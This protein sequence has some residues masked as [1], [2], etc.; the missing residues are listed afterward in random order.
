VSYRLALTDN[1]EWIGRLEG[2][3]DHLSDPLL[4]AAMPLSVLPPL[5]PYVV[6]LPIPAREYWC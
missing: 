4:A 6:D 1:L 3:V 2:E 5:G